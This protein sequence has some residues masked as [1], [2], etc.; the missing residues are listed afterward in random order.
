MKPPRILICCGTG[1]VGKT[2]TAAALG[3]GQALAGHRVAVL[4]IDPA[5]RL[6]DALGLDGLAND[7][8]QVDLTGLDGTPGG[9]LHALMLDKKQTFDRAIVQ[10]SADPEAAGKMLSNRYYRAVSTRLTGAHEYMATEKLHELASGGDFDVI[11]LDTP[12]SQHALE[13]FHAP[14]RLIELFD[15]PVM[16]RLTQPRRG[17]TG[18]ATRRVFRYLLSLVGQSVMD[19][20]S[21]FFRLFA[22]VSEGFS[23]HSRDVSTWLRADSTDIFLVTS[24]ST[25]SRRGAL[26]FI[27]VI[28]RDGFSFRG[29]FVNRCQT[30]LPLIDAPLDVHVPAD[31]DPD[32]WAAWMQQ[33]DLAHHRREAIADRHERACDELSRQGGGAPVWAL[34][35]VTD[36]LRSLRGLAALSKHLPSTR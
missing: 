14:E 30:R 12:P 11:V 24:A 16:S 10:L 21:E 22:S 33:L 25:V 9:S 32:A 19:D 15:G 29:F 3:V 27:E 23:A 26:D 4:T 6:A 8:K 17:L 7:P 31:M 35:I 34:P 5:R 2:T 36:G 20:I 28:K 13:F 1:G 18:G